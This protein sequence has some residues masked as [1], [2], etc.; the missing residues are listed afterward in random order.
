MANTV[1]DDKSGRGKTRKAFGA[2]LGTAALTAVYGAH[3][4]ANPI[5]REHAIYAL[6]TNA[7]G[8]A[9]DARGIIARNANIIGQ[10]IASKTLGAR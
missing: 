5:D 3:T 10:G 4:G 9:H 1:H 8:G 2:H 6:G 7:R